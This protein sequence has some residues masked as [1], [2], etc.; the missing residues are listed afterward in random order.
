M[1]ATKSNKI[2]EKGT[3]RLWKNYSVYD[4]ETRYTIHEDSACNS[5]EEISYAFNGDEIGLVNEVIKRGNKVDFTDNATY[6]EYIAHLEAYR[7]GNE[8]K[9]P[10]YPYCSF[11][12][13][14]KAKEIWDLLN[15]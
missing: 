14:E 5:L 8:P 7:N 13:Y 3:L 4:K 11:E 2:H 1:G 12:T 9:N 15:V 6:E 10:I